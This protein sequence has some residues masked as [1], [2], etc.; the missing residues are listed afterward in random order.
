MPVKTIKDSS[1]Q[2]RQLVMPGHTNALGT[3]FG[4]AMLGWVDG[5]CAMAAQKHAQQTV[6]TVYMDDITFKGPVCLGDHVVIHARVT[7]AGRTSLGVEA[8]AFRENPIQGIEELCLTA[9]LIFVA[10]GPEGKPIPVPKLVA[11]NP[12]ETKMM[13]EAKDR[14]SQKSATSKNRSL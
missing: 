8:M 5:A 2:Y 11:T 3:L 6:V 14:V 1:I 9:F 4:G 10:L 12:E 13:A 7:Y